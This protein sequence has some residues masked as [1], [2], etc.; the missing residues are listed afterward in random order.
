MMPGVDHKKRWL[1]AVAA[2]LLA[3]PWH[4]VAAQDADSA[5]LIAW[6]C[7]LGKDAQVSIHCLHVGGSDTLAEDAHAGA[8]FDPQRFGRDLLAGGAAP[9]LA[10]LV[11]ADAATYGGR[12]WLIPLYNYPFN[13]ERVVQLARAVVCGRDPHCNVHFETAG[14]GNASEPR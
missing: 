3:L 8:P 9:N 6:Q 4:V 5:P 14:A 7:W 10:R 2:L 1:S 11:R 12:L 13:T